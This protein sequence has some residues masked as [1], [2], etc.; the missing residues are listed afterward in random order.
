M[1]HLL[2]L[3]PFPSRSKKH[4]HKSHSRSPSPQ[5]SPNER[6][7]SRRKK[8]SKK[9]RRHHHKSRT[10]SPVEDVGNRRDR[11]DSGGSPKT[12]GRGSSEGE[13]S[14]VVEK[15]K[16]EDPDTDS[17]YDWTCVEIWTI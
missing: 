4:R 7:S 13:G 11:E 17:S 3:T 15:V 14:P 10:P 16:N 12:S 6:S 8:H 1:C 9:H 2:Q 5:N